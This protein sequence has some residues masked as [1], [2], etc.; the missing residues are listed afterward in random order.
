MKK[1]SVLR[2]SMVA[3]PT[4][5]IYGLLVAASS[6]RVAIKN[7]GQVV[8]TSTQRHARIIPFKAIMERPSKACSL[9]SP[10]F[11]PKRSSAQ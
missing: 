1:K 11:R 10:G 9:T 7:G 3:V 5:I 4:I 8:T 6:A 2:M